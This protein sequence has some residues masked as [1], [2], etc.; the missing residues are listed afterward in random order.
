MTAFPNAVRFDADTL[1]VSLSDG[2]TI[3]ALLAQ[4]E[5]SQHGLHWDAL[6]ED[7]LYGLD[8]PD[9]TVDELWAHEAEARLAAFREGRVQ[10]I[11]LSEVLAKY[12]LSSKTIASY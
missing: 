12:M 11:P 9:P 2:R 7:I 1:W 8:A 6:D 10:A 5:M 4:V 3:A